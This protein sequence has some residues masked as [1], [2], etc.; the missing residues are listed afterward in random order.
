[1][2]HLTRYCAAPLA[3]K[4]ILVNCIIPGPFPRID[5]IEYPNFL[6]YLGDKTM[7]GRVGHPK[8][9]VGPVALLC[10]TASSFMTGASITVDGGWTAW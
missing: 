3:G 6:N 9:I 1:M 4:N 10:S 5:W 7:L 2:I 8:E